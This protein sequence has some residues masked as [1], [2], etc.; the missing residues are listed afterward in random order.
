[1]TLLPG[2]SRHHLRR[3]K[4]YSARVISPILITT[5]AQLQICQRILRD[6]DR[7]WGGMDAAQNFHIFAC[8]VD[9]TARHATTSA[10]TLHA[11]H[12]ASEIHRAADSV[13]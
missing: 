12:D 7:V 13:H 11:S 4:R 2:E 8:D 9:G 5:F 10:Q 6:L 3:N 1:M